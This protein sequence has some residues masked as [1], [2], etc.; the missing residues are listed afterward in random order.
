MLKNKIFLPVAS[1]T[2]E[3]EIAHDVGERDIM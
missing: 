2:S 3:A 1:L